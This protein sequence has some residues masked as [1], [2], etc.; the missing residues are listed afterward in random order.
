MPGHT[1]RPLLLL[2]GDHKGHGICLSPIP[3]LKLPAKWQR[4]TVRWGE[5]LPLTMRL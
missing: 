3:G 1:P 2:Q 5:P 4:P